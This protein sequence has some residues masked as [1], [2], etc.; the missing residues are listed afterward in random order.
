MH[1]MLDSGYK[2]NGNDEFE[3]DFE[4]NFFDVIFN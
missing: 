2:F 4:E 1:S 3:L